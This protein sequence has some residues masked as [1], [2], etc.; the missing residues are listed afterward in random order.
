MSDLADM[1]A[2]YEERGYSALNATARVCQDVILRKIAES[3]LSHNLTVKGGVLM[4]AVTRNRR[5]ATQDIDLDLIA[6]L[7]MTRP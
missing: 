5:R 3:S 2:A 6:I 4:C 7:S 1:R